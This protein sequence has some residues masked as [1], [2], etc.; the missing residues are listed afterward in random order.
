[1]PIT[2]ASERPVPAS[3]S[4][5]SASVLSTSTV[6]PPR[7][8]STSLGRVAVPDGRFSAM[9]I[10][11]VMRTGRF[12]RAAASVTASTVAAPVMSYFIPTMDAAGFSESPPESKVIP[13]P[14]SARCG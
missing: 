3:T 7:M 1:M 9:H 6:F 8:W 5:P 10:H 4:L 2:C 14:T 13:L 11:A 12:R